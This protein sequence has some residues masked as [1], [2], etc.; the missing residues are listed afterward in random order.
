[1]NRL[2]DLARERQCEHFRHSICASVALNDLLHGD[3]RQ[4]TSLKLTSYLAFK[5][6]EKS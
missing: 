2:P 6:H 4:L 1:M 5:A 3:R